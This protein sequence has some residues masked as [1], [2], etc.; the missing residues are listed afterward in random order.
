MVLPR[1]QLTFAIAV[2]NRLLIIE[3]LLLATVGLFG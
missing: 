1:N 2:F 3:L